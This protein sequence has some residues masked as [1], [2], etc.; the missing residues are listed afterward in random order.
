MNMQRIAFTLVGLF[1]VGLFVFGVKFGGKYRTAPEMVIAVEEVRT[2]DYPED[3]AFRSIFYDRYGNRRL[4]LR[5]RENHHFDF[6]FESD[7]PK[8]A[9]ISLVNIDL[10]LF[11]PCIPENIRE[12]RDLSIVALVD[13]EWNR[14]QVR[15]TSGHPKLRIEGGDG[16][17]KTHTTTVEIARNCLNAGLWEVI[18]T[19]EEQGRKALYYQGWFTFPLGFYKKIFEILNQTSYWKHWFRL[20]H[21]L[22]PEGKIMD[23]SK[24]RTVETEKVVQGSCDWNEAVIVN[25]EQ[26]RKARTVS[27][28][29]VRCWGD[30]CKKRDKIRF[31]SFIPPGRYS[32]RHPWNNEYQRIETFENA[33]V[34]TTTVAN[35]HYPL[36]EV[37]LVFRDGGT[38]EKTCFLVSGI[39]IEQLPFL[40]D[41]QY[42]QG[43]YMPMGIGVPPFYQD[44]DELGEN[45]PHQSPYFSFLLDRDGR[46]INHHEVGIDGPVLHRDRKDPSKLHIYLLSYERHTLIGHYIVPL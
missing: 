32:V 38:G 46:W 18:L 9:T 24:L 44:Y 7:D 41:V 22:N 37:E 26:I 23:L 33:I 31:A 19:K 21:W 20:E 13:R 3:P 27:A 10:S 40:D 6:I 17:E 4:R 15:F 11:V 28:Q 25:G 30:F 2:S 34:R 8:V 39:D 45:P 36:L 12:D 1:V 16:F 29:G 5:E 43:F 14:Q 35:D 42:N